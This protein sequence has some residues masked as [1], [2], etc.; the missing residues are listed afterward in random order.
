M[1]RRIVSIVFVVVLM[2]P[3][4]IVAEIPQVISY[5]GKI[6]DSGGTSVP[7]GSYT[8]RFRIMDG[9]TGANVLWDSGNR[10]IA[11]S[12][13]VFSVLLGES[14]QPSLD[15]EFDQEYWLLVTFEG[16]NQ[17][18]RQPLASTGYAYMASG[19]VAGTEVV[20][21]VDT[22]AMTALKVTNRAPTGFTY[23]VYG[24]SSSTQGRGVCGHATAT[25]GLVYGIL[26]RC[27][28]TLGYG[29]YGT[30]T[31][32]SGDTNG[33]YGV[34]FSSTGR[35][36]LG[37]A[38][39]TTGAAFGVYG[40]SAST[41]GR[42]VHGY[43]A[44]TSGNAYGVYGESSSGQG[45]GVYAKATSTASGG[46]Y[47]IYADGEFTGLYCVSHESDAIIGFADSGIG[48]SYGVKGESAGNNGVGVYG[49][50]SN[51][52]GDDSHGVY[53]RTDGDGYGV[54]YSGGLAGSGS[55]S[56]MVKTSRGPTLLYCQESPE[57]WFEDFGEG[58]LAQGR[59]YVELAVLMDQDCFPP[60]RMPGSMPGSDL[61]LHSTVPPIRR[62]LARM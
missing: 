21:S 1:N 44:A 5:Q 61:I 23:G 37:I 16:V 9:P 8:M 2:T 12:G 62:P 28:S 49:H 13:G 36:V 43:A 3:G 6:T 15:L 41:S 32:T 42:G 57:N 59:A 39:S 7:D 58:Q 27:D 50:A 51:D 10:T 18:P 17:T 45:V 25:S 38:A 56:C 30:A 11:T 52:I 34:S 54:Y 29:V 33:V 35:G 24:V 22:G 19:L 26:G 53:G 47:A 14:P 55:K 20:G 46:S 31:A 60:F 4:L 40:S 48:A